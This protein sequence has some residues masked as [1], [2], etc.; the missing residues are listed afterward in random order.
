MST[1]QTIAIAA[2][3]TTSYWFFVGALMVNEVST[4]RDLITGLLAS[5][6][7]YLYVAGSVVALYIMG[8]AK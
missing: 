5:A 4:T 1:I 6:G 3:F 7:L 2:I 8:R